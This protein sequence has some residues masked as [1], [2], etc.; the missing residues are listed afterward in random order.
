MP[1]VS[2]AGPHY[3]HLTPS[4]G[5]CSYLH[6]GLQEGSPQKA[7]SGLPSADTLT[8]CA[9]SP[10]HPMHPSPCHSPTHGL[11][12]HRPCPPRGCPQGGGGSCTGEQRREGLPTHL[13]QVSRGAHPIPI[14]ILSTLSEMLV[15]FPI[16]AL[17]V[18][19]SLLICT[20]A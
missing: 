15:I 4:A 19:L 3:L 16:L 1:C 10:A 5:R 2:L 6:P 18:L 11:P 20:L 17:G 12:N 14:L 9:W 8:L 7:P 13:S